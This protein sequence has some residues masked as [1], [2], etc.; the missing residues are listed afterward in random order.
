MFVDKCVFCG[1]LFQ[2][3]SPPQLLQIKRWAISGLFDPSDNMSPNAVVREGQGPERRGPIF[4]Q[5]KLGGKSDKNFSD[6]GMT[7]RWDFR[8]ME[9]NKLQP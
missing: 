1:R 8:R 7:S 6:A 2:L 4:G 5:N 9:F 3:K